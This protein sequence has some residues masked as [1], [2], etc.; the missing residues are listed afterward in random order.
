MLSSKKNNQQPKNSI[1]M[2]KHIITVQHVHKAYGKLKA[3]EDLSFQ[4]SSSMCFGFLGP[5]G[6]GKTTMM[7][8]IYGKAMRDKTSESNVSV[9]GCD[10]QF[11]A[12]DIK[13]IAGIAP[14][15]NNL[16]VELNVQ[17]NMD[18]YAKL[19]NIPR[20]E[21]HTRIEKLLEFMELQDKKKAKIR[22]LSGGMVRRLLIVRALLNEPR[23]LI[24]DEPTTGLDP[25][26]RHLIWNKIRQLK[27][28]GTTVLLTTHYMEEAYNLAD[29]ILV[30]HEGKKQIE[31]NP[32]ALLKR[33]MET[34]VLEILD[35][36]VIDS[37]PDI[38]SLFGLRAEESQETIYFY[39]DDLEQL[40][41]IS[42]RFD[43]GVYFTRQT[44]LEDLF[45]KLTGR[46]LHDQQ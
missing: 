8:I 16:D 38:E 12:L 11:N 29:T 40:K 1:L 32:R 41:S 45:L 19:Y 27:K 25:Q 13:H 3:V 37:I 9:F 17:Q 43:P 42:A 35:K 2:N 22:E 46:K 44:N 7:K 5:N 30:L 34:Y 20:Q 28:E 31:G 4:V 39:S 18:I 36:S 15:D 24:L 33:Y 6:A 10:P 26:V 23:L 21:A 14:Q